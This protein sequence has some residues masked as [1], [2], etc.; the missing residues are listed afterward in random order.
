MSDGEVFQYKNL[1]P[2]RVGI[3]FVI[4]MVAPDPLSVPVCAA[5]APVPPL[6]LNESVLVINALFTVNPVLP[7]ASGAIPFDTVQNKRVSKFGYA[8]LKFNAG[9]NVDPVPTS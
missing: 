2:S 3:E 6:A 9:A 4:V 1:Y 7:V 5:G 8:V